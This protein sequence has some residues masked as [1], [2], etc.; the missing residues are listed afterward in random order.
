MNKK[1]IIYICCAI[2]IIL[3]IAFATYFIVKNVSKT[4]DDNSSVEKITITRYD[5]DSNVD[6]EIEITDKKQLKELKNICESPS[7]EQDDTT[8]NLAIKNDVKVDFNNGVFFMIQ[9]ELEEYCYYEDANTNT[10]L[11]IKMPQGLLEKVNDIL[12]KN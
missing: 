8:I 10:K 12:A 2:A 11:I 9:L 6:K 1:T 4:E 3:I 7:L 5:N